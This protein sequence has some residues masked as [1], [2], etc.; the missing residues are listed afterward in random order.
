MLGSSS[1]IATTIPPV[2]RGGSRCP[3]AGEAVEAG[4]GTGFRRTG[5]ALGTAAIR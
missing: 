5:S 4:D 2:E 3:V 1:P